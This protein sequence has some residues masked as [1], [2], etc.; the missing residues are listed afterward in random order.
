MKSLGNRVLKLI[1][2][3]TLTTVSS[4]CQQQSWVLPTADGGR[5]PS[6]PSVHGYLVKV[7]SKTIVV[8]RDAEAGNRVSVQLKARTQFF[9]AYGGLYTPD[10]LRAGQYVWVWYVTA[11]PAKAGKPPAAAVVVLWSRDAAD[12][13]S[14]KVRQSYDENTEPPAR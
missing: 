14:R 11:D 2:A 9:T 8:R 4:F 12:K 13:P 7:V 3:A 5:K 1:I 10:Q 6:P